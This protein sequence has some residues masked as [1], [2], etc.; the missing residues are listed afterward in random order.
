MNELYIR[1]HVRF[2]KPKAVRLA[3][4]ALVRAAL[5]PSL[6]A[7]DHLRRLDAVLPLPGGGEK[8]AECLFDVRKWTLEDAQELMVQNFLGALGAPS[9]G[10]GEDFAGRLA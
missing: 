1:T 2:E 3:G 9:E 5:D 8:K 6:D 7:K 10:E 4:A